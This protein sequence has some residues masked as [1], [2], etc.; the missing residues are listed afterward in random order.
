MKHLLASLV[1]V[2]LIGGSQVVT[3]G[4]DSGNPVG[5]LVDTKEQGAKET[6]KVDDKVAESR[7]APVSA[8]PRL[9]A[10]VDSAGPRLDAEVDLLKHQ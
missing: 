2:G 3:Y 5:L 4:E 7:V 8:G 1:A 10:E 9:D 6:G